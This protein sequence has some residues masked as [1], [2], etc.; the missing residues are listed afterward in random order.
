MQWRFKWGQ[1]PL[2]PFKG[3]LPTVLFPRVKAQ[4][5]RQEFRFAWQDEHGQHAVLIA[6]VS[7]SYLYVQLEGD[8]LPGF[9]KIDGRWYVPVKDAREQIAHMKALLEE[10]RG[11]KVLSG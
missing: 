6:E 2:L 11:E 8:P 4:P 5:R 7:E 1:H 3:G 9:P 10:W